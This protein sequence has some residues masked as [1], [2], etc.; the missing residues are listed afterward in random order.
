[1]FARPTRRPPPHQQHNAYLARKPH[2]NAPS[3]RALPA[4]T[5]APGESDAN[6]IDNLS[7][8]D[9]DPDA[10][11]DS[12]DTKAAKRAAS[13]PAAHASR[14]PQ[15]HTRSHPQSAPNSD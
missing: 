11:F 14:P 6:L 7:L 2:S 13:K 8:S 1:M 10:L 12:P 9:S 3:S 15:S 4:P 5:M